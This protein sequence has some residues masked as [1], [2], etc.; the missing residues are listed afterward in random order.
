[1]RVVS[2]QTQAHKQ[3]TNHPPSY[4]TTVYATM[5]TTSPRP[6][7]QSRATRYGLSRFS[8]PTCRTCLTCLTPPARS[9]LPPL[10]R[11]RERGPGGEGGVRANPS[12][13]TTYAP[14]TILPHHSLRNHEDH[15]TATGDTVPGYALWLVSVLGTDLSD[16]SD[17]SDCPSARRFSPSPAGDEWLR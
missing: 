3:L 5:K 1:M 16:L 6:G 13:K 10:A 15:L 8:V 11:W 12:A 7:T 4:H 9:A 17:L 2:A 14:S